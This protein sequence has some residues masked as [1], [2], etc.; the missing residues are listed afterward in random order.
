MLKPSLCDYS[1][2][3]ML[4]SGAITVAALEAGEGNNNIQVVLKNC[5]PFTNCK[6]EKY[7]AQIDN[8]KD[9]NVVMS[10]YNL[11]EYSEEVYRNTIE[12]NQL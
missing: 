3:Y 10:M 2:P 1:D 7:N 11:I 4:V 6:S 5:A 12:M 8:A 9:I